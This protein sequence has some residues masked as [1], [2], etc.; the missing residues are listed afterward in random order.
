MI[1]VALTYEQVVE[2]L[3]A[4]AAEKP[5]YVYRPPVDMG[6]CAY[7]AETGVPSCIVGHVI[8]KH[9]VTRSDLSLP[10]TDLNWGSGPERLAKY[11]VIEADTRTL[12]LLGHAQ[13]HQDD[14]HTWQWSVDI[15]LECVRLS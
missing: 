10:K 13:Q 6:T 4:L 15:A 14:G 2:D 12:S 3:K 8:A 7:F 5:D 11:G 9:G 1:G